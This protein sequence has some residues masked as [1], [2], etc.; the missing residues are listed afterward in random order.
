MAINKL[1]RL[2]LKLL[3]YPDID[4]RKTYQ[5]ER[6]I[7]YL[8]LPA[9]LPKDRWHD[10]TIVSNGKNILTRVY[11]PKNDTQQNTL[12][13]F[14]GGGWVT[15]SIDTYNKVCD[16]LACATKSKVISVE[17]RLAPEHP[18]P[19]GLE[20]CYAACLLYTSDAADE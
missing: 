20:D 4:I 8:K 17:Y 19:Q 16:A 3:S 15:E 18:F 14:H 2:A 1:M 10:Y 11:I 7:Q 6:S 13:F 5:L 12:L 9:L